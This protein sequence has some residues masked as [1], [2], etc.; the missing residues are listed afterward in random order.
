MIFSYSGFSEKI[1]KQ[2]RLPEILLLR[3][4]RDHGDVEKAWQTAKGKLLK[5]ARALPVWL[6]AMETAV[7]YRRKPDDALEIL[8][9]LC[10]TDEF[11]YDHR[12]VAVGMMQGLDGGGGIQL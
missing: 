12:V 7:L 5:E 2:R 1:R 10:V 11:H 6:F 8:K 3:H 4:W 9:Q